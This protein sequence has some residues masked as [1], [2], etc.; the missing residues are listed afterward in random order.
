MPVTSKASTV[1]AIALA[2][3][4][5][6][7]CSA[8][9]TNPSATK[10]T[11]T[12]PVATVN[13]E[14]IT[15]A[16]L[17]EAVGGRVTA[18][19]QQIYQAK[20]D[21]I[22]GLAF[23]RVLEAAAKAADQTP[24]AYYKANVTDK[25]TEPA[26][27]MVT[28]LLNQYRSQLPKD[29]AQARTQ[30]IAY[31]KQQ[32]G[33]SL[34]EQ[35]RSKLLGDA[36]LVVLLEPPRQ[37]SEPA[38]FNPAKG[39]ADAPVTIVEFSDFQCPFCRRAQT[40]VD[41]VLKRYDGKIRYVYR[42]LPLEMHDNARTAAEASL[43]AD[44]QGK[45]WPLHDWMF[46]HQQELSADSL[47]A[48]AGELGLDATAFASCLDEKKHA[49]QVDQDMAEAQRLGITGT[50]GFLINGRLI[51]GAQPLS[52]FVEVINDE[53]RRAGVEIPAPAKEAAPAPAATPAS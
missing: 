26:E 38:A 36:N 30:V 22:R 52:T 48:K 45:F 42:Q 6:I 43:C 23:Q 24:E 11:P 8:A 41:E 20:V 16:Q 31:L 2:A 53:L 17:N 25:I 46:Q 29:E 51:S 1:L 50:P 47:K 14:P 18:L 15:A 27:Q 49:A 44:D 12:D 39:P 10:S 7:A 37:E 4:V 13:G 33:R 40:V 32:Q 5:A 21:G 28:S 3:V 9:D 19:E 34:D 35:L